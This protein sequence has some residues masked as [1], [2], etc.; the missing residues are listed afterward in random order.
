LIMQHPF[1]FKPGQTRALVLLD[2]DHLGSASESDID[3]AAMSQASIPLPQSDAVPSAMP[4]VTTHRRHDALAVSLDHSTS[5]R[6]TELP[7]PPRPPSE[8]SYVATTAASGGAVDVASRSAQTRRTAH[9]FQLPRIV[10]VGSLSKDSTGGEWPPAKHVRKLATKEADR[11]LRAR[12]DKLQCAEE[13]RY[14]DLPPQGKASQ[15]AAS[16][17]SNSVAF[18]A[19][20]RGTAFSPSHFGA[21]LPHLQ[22]KYPASYVRQVLQAMSHTLNSH[23]RL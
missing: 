22:M 16:L 6:A 23:I 3:W 14:Y 18:S 13:V 8:P 12:R 2:A 20:A 5:H 7:G 15:D 11:I 10:S 17:D 9:G 19:T 4:Q 21:D 1:V